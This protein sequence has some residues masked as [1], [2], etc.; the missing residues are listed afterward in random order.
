MDYEITK[1]LSNQPQRLTSI[2]GRKIQYRF[3]T[4]LKN[5][6]SYS[7]EM[8]FRINKKKVPMIKGMNEFYI[9]EIGNIYKGNYY[10]FPEEILIKKGVITVDKKPGK[11]HLIIK[12]PE[13]KDWSVEY[14]NNFDLLRH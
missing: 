9:C 13:K 6:D 2:M 14:L 10:V 11:L 5:S 3:T 12:M 4:Y 1:K 7:F 8:N